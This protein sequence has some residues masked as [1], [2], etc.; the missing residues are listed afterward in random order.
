MG[1]R[2]EIIRAT[3]LAPSKHLLDQRGVKPVDVIGR[4]NGQPVGPIREIGQ[5]DAVAADIDDQRIVFKLLPSRPIKTG[6]RDAQA[7]IVDIRAVE[8]D[9]APVAKMIVRCQENRDAA[10]PGL[11]RK[12]RRCRK[13]R[14]AGI[15]QHADRKLHVRHYQV[16]LLEPWLAGFPPCRSAAVTWGPCDIT[17]PIKTIRTVSG[18]PAKAAW[19]SAR[20]SNSVSSFPLVWIIRLYLACKVN[21][22]Y[23]H[24]QREKRP[25]RRITY[26][27]PLR[28][29]LLQGI[30][31]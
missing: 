18:L 16:S 5:R 28:H 24:R 15:R 14:I 19:Q 6:E 27:N 8:P 17:S 7:G 3:G 22:F 25:N 11:L 9:P 21:L 10:S 1:K 12:G 26:K 30:L 13:E 29:K 2:D 20:L 31:S 4:R 23:G